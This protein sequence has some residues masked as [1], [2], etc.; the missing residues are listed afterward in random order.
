MT[1]Y[2][3]SKLDE[4]WTKA[5]VVSL[6]IVE[7]KNSFSFPIEHLEQRDEAFSSSTPRYRQLFPFAKAQL[8][9]CRIPEPVDIDTRDWQALTEENERLRDMVLERDLRLSIAF[10][11]LKKLGWKEAK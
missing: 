4:G 10:E 3:W 9:K 6:T 1:R 2:D 8:A 11:R 7:E 5:G